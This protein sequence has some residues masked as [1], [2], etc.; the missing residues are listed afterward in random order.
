[1][2]ELQLIAGGVSTTIHDD[3]SMSS[4]AV[5][6]CDDCNRDESTLGGSSYFDELGGEILW[7]CALCKTAR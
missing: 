4:I 6:R 1:M 3:G 2:G 7:I 5:R